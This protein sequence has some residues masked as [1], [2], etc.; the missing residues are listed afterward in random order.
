MQSA[1][2][3]LF[4]LPVEKAGHPQPGESRKEQAKLL[5]PLICLYDLYTAM[6]CILSYKEFSSRRY[7]D[8]RT[9]ST[10]TGVNISLVRRGPAVATC[11][12]ITPTYERFHRSQV[13]TKAA[14][15]HDELVTR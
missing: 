13:G 2:V 11:Q 5:M 7:P 4:E 3:P 15:G 12:Q 14:L 1:P 6:D 8:G 10:T 9:T